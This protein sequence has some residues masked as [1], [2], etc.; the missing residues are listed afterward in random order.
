MKRRDFLQSSTTAALALPMAALSPAALSPGTFVHCV[1][2]WMKDD[3]TEEERASFEEGL[4]SL[5]RL[6]MVQDGYVGT[7]AATDRPIIDRSYSYA[8]VLIF[9]DVTA[10]DAY[11][12]DPDHDVFRESSSHLWK[13][14]K[15]YDFQTM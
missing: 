10:Q 3:L 6:D 8:L 14:V 1:F 12:Q 2:F 11:Q 7:P 15:I 13:E 9:E 4:S 5:T